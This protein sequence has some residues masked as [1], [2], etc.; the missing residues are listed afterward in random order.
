[1]KFNIEGTRVASCDTSSGRIYRIEF[2]HTNRHSARGR[3]RLAHFTG[4]DAMTTCVIVE[5]ER[6]AIHTAF[7]STA[8]YHHKDPA[9]RFSYERAR[10]IALKGALEKYKGWRKDIP[11]ILRAYQTRRTV[12]WIRED[13]LLGDGREHPEMPDHSVIIGPYTGGPKEERA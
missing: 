8:D 10:M 5:G 9:Q 7:C 1:M 11:A 12:E 6:V 13:P 4:F 3:H 2:Q